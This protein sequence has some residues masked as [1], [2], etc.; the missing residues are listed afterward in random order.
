MGLPDMTRDELEAHAGRLE[1][2]LVEARELAKRH[3]AA[4][5]FAEREAAD[6]R[7]RGT[8][9]AINWIRAMPRKQVVTPRIAV[10]PTV[11]QIVAMSVA[12]YLEERLDVSEEVTRPELPAPSSSGE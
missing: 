5:I 9:D 1:L 10:G 4:K 8:R 11:Y 6:A 12:R 2:E 3:H 7:A